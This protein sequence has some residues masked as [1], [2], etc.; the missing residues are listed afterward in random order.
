VD[1]KVVNY[2]EVE[3]E[4]VEEGAQATRIRWLITEAD[5]ARNFVMR[6]F[7]IA[8]GGFTPY[9]DHAWE[10]EVFVLEGEGLLRTEAGPRPVRAGDVVFVPGNQKHQFRNGGS[11]PLAFLCLIPAR[12]D[13]L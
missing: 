10:H 8:P 12:Q 7:E 13:K 9:H 3:A 6:H 11:V 1:L 5:G 2:S 4:A